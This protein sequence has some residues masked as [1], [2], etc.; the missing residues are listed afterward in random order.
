MKVAKLLRIVSTAKAAVCTWGSGS[1][2][3][4]REAKWGRAPAEALNDLLG[5][6]GS[7]WSAG[8]GAA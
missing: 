2:D 3:L 1:L 7:V 6:L 5:S 8:G 4:R